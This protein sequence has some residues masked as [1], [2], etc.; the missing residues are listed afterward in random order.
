M[1][2][3]VMN[4]YAIVAVAPS[5]R[6]DIHVLLGVR[7]EPREWVVASI[8]THEVT[9]SPESWNNGSYYEDE[10]QAVEVYLSEIATDPSDVASGLWTVFCTV[11]VTKTGVV[12]EGSRT[13]K[14][15]GRTI[16]HNDD[17]WVDP[18]ATGDDRMWRE[19]C[20]GH[21]TFTAEHE[22]TTEEAS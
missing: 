8:F 10:H 4:G 5:T 13:C 2:G 11:D 15:C 22:P 9:R 16:V 18:Q 19:T 1:I 21:D 12:T 6:E 20:E 7:H 17:G 14:H 3:H